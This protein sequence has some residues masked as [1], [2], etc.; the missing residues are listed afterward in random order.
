MDLARS[1]FEYNG[2]S[3]KPAVQV[4]SWTPEQATEAPTRHSAR[5]RLLHRSMSNKTSRWWCIFVVDRA[6]TS[7]AGRPSGDIFVSPR[8]SP[9]SGSPFRLPQHLFHAKMRSAVLQAMM[10]C[11]AKVVPWS[12]GG[13]C[14]LRLAMLLPKMTFF[15]SAATMSFSLSDNRIQI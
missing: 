2:G 3:S 8:E 11:S 10:P 13:A 7:L 6:Q 15:R 1:F 9:F 14:H 12:R 4:C 5:Y